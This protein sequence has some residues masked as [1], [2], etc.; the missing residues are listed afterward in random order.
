MY[1]LLK[2]FLVL[3]ICIAVQD[4]CYGQKNPAKHTMA[5]SSGE[6]LV[7]DLHYGFISGGKISLVSERTF[8]NGKKA[9]HL[10]I[11][12][13]TVGMVDAL[14]KI[15][16]RYESYVDLKTDLPIKS[17]R[18]IREG[19][20]KYYNEVYFHRNDIENDSCLITSKRSGDHRMPLGIHDIVSAFYYARKFNYNDNL[21]KNEVIEFT[22]YFSDEIFPLRIRFK[23]IETIKTKFGKIECYKF[24]PVTEVGR[25]F[26]TE[27][28]MVIWISR[29]KNRIPVKATI[30]LAVGSFSCTLIEFQGLYNPFASVK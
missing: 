27:E 13:K 23:G 15:R 17:V 6:K 16:D 4:D 25:A 14:Y 3:Y 12:G 9:N 8:I 2:K 1:Q 21:K 22:T 29:D 28:D 24:S 30:D 5:Y 7:Y 20:Y 18:N 10:S 19:R 11:T 26:K